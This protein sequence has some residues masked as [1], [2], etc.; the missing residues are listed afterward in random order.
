MARTPKTSGPRRLPHRRPNEELWG[1]A[2][3]DGRTNF[4][5]GVIVAGGIVRSVPL[6][7]AWMEGRDWLWCA[8]KCEE[9]GWRVWQSDPEAITRQ[10]DR[11]TRGVVQTA[12]DLG[13][14]TTSP[15]RP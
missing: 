11:N 7:L 14:P 6:L 8:G 3:H 4:V 1:V 10:R 9:K 2:G 12:L 13:L 15:H 5:T